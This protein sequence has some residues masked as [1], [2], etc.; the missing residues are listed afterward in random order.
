MMKIT[1][2]LLLTLLYCGCHTYYRVP[3][4]NSAP[5][6][7][8]NSTVCVLLPEAHVT[9]AV[10][11][12]HVAQY[13]CG[14][15]VPA[16]IDVAIVE[17]RT[18]EA[19]KELGFIQNTADKYSGE[20]LGQV[21]KSEIRFSPDAAPTFVM[22][23]GSDADEAH[24]R[25]SVG[26]QPVVVLTASYSYSLNFHTLVLVVN[27]KAYAQ[28]VS[29]SPLYHNVLVAEADTNIAQAVDAKRNKL[30]PQEEVAFRKAFEIAASEIAKMLLFDISHCP[31][32]DVAVFGGTCSGSSPV[33]IYA[34]SDRLWMRSPNGTLTSR[35]KP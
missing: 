15:L 10:A 3:D 33:A 23:T 14:G 30:T 8:K 11:P 31:K 21:L 19:E 35:V 20:V 4:K 29:G 2:L 5:P 9:P 25:K 28:G 17:H 7:A 34:S 24:L 26:H 12:S 32:D 27:A 1:P 6:V 22:R 18:D 13:T 16:L